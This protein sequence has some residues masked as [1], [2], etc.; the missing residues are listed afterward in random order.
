MPGRSEYYLSRLRNIWFSWMAASCG[1]PMRCSIAD[2]AFVQ[3]AW[4]TT[5][6]VCFTRIHAP[7]VPNCARSILEIGPSAAGA[8]GSSARAGA[9]DAW[10]GPPVS[11]GWALVRPSARNV[12]R[13][14][15]PSC[16]LAGLGG[17]DAPVTTRVILAAAHVNHDPARSGDRNLRAWC[18]RCDL[19]CTGIE[20]GGSA[21]SFPQPASPKSAPVHLTR[22][23][24]NP[25]QWSAP[26]RVDRLGHLD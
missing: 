24:V 14:P 20:P 10:H 3:K 15:R 4:T 22:A 6:R 18:Q 16:T 19:P 1:S 12:A 11:S 7:S 23:T 13:S 26:L 5:T 8:F 21:R 17:H 25:S 9:A 2:G